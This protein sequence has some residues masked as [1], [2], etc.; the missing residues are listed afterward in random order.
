MHIRPYVG[1]PLLHVEQPHFTGWRRLL[2]RGGDDWFP[3]HINFF[4]R[5]PLESLVRSQGLRIVASKVVPAA[6][7]PALVVKM[8]GG[9]RAYRENPLARMVFALLR[10]T[11]V[12]RVLAEAHGA[13][14]D[15][16]RDRQEA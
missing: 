1:L 16:G 13:S 15:G 11:Q 5:R 9:P 3:G 8:L 7:L 4:T 6:D 10:L 2:K 12:E 14:T